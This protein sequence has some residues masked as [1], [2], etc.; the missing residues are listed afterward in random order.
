VIVGGDVR[1]TERD[2]HRILRPSAWIL[3]DLVLQYNFLFNSLLAVF[4]MEMAGERLTE[5]VGQAD[6]T[7]YAAVHGDEDAGQANVTKKPEV[8]TDTIAR[9]AGPIQKIP[10]PSTQELMA[11]LD[12]TEKKYELYRPNRNLT[13]NAA[14]SEVTGTAAVMQNQG[15][16]LMLSEDLVNWDSAHKRMFEETVH[17][18]CFTSYFEDEDE[19]TRY[20]ATVSGR[21]NVKGSRGGMSPGDVVYLDAKKC[22]NPVSFSAETSKDTPA[23]RRDREERARTAKAAGVFTQLD[24]FEAYG[25]FD[26]EMQ[27]EL[28]FAE[29]VEAFLKP[30][31]LRRVAA[32]VAARSASRTGV[33]MGEEP[34]VQNLPLPDDNGPQ[35]YN[36]LEANNARVAAPPVT[37]PPTTNPGMGGSSGLV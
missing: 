4:A 6:P 2:P 15:A 37:L 14:I 11:L 24:V 22:A 23:D 18:I 1:K 21:E 36:T 34:L 7:I 20:I 16:G 13:G 29:Q 19:Q 25:V 8:G 35:S 5:N 17:G 12:K 10:G 33:D 3:L 30:L 31:E 27:E 9:M 28:L 32:L 26:I